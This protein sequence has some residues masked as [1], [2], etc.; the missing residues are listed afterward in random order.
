M[1][2]APL[3]LCFC[4]AFEPSSSRRRLFLRLLQPFFLAPLRLHWILHHDQ[5]LARALCLLSLVDGVGPF[6][7][8][9]FVFIRPC[10]ATLLYLIESTTVRM[11]RLYVCRVY[12]RV[13][14]GSKPK[15]WR[16]GA[17]QRLLLVFFLRPVQTSAGA[18][19]FVQVHTVYL[20]VRPFFYSPV[21]SV[22]K[23]DAINL[24]DLAQ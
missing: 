10:I 21:W 14:Q 12:S 23:V 6:V 5:Q 1:Y 7:H 13:G 3:L 8:Y 19:V 9:F 24:K 20:F 22:S 17:A 4:W 16:G 15:L 18:C 2:M 11:T